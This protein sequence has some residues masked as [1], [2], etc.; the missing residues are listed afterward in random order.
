MLRMLIINKVLHLKAVIKFNK[1]WA[2]SVLVCLLMIDSTACFSQTLSI[3]SNDLK[4]LIN[5][6]FESN[7]DLAIS[8]SEMELSRVEIAGQVADLKPKISAYSR[9]HWY[10]DEQPVTVFPGNSWLA[11]PA[12]MQNENNYLSTGLPSN[13]GVGIVLEQTLFDYRFFLVNKT[14]TTFNS[15]ASIRT[16]QSQWEIAYEIAKQFYELNELQSRQ[17]LLTFNKKR[18]EKA[19]KILRIQVQNDM[20]LN[21]ELEKTE[22]KLEKLIVL[23][24]R[25]SSGL[26]TKTEYIKSIAGFSDSTN[27]QIVINSNDTIPAI[28]TLTQNKN[29][30][31]NY[32]LL[33]QLKATNLLKL[34]AAKS[35]YLP[36]MNFFADINWF[37]QSSDFST[38]FDSDNLN[39]QGFV[40]LKLNIPI[41][42]GGSFRK[43]QQKTGIENEIYKLKQQQLIT[44]E[45]LKYKKLTDELTSYTNEWVIQQKLEAVSSNQYKQAE[46]RF[47][48]G[49]I[50]INSLLEAEEEYS[51][52]V[53]EK[54]E[55]LLKIKLTELELLKLSGN[56]ETL[57]K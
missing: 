50:N 37:S 7:T 33:D 5:K 32:H 22:L 23:E 36:S 17:Q 10:Y 30:S 28:A 12:Y 15:I 45:K 13:L 26:Q 29:E 8:R 48:E 24:Q 39:H 46:N 56:I 49:T 16:Q 40:G 53:S 34:S 1:G 9:Y 2:F 43:L 20:A 57:Y 55:L 4:S 51:K 18:L 14:K 19:V 31:I 38:Q 6:A 35:E 21:S 3:V 42:S 54:N 11:N 27:L 41:Y 47:E 52:S 44:G 25:L